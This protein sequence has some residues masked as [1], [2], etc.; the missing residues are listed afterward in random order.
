MNILKGNGF[1][2]ENGGNEIVEMPD[3]CPFCHFSIKPILL[4]CTHKQFNY[5]EVFMVCP[6]ENCQSSFIAYYDQIEK[7]LY[8]FTGFVSKGRPE[9]RNFSEVINKISSSF[10]KIYN[11]A[12]A[13]EQNNLHEICGMA[14]R[15][16]FEFLI[17]DYLIKI[18]PKERAFIK[19]QTR[20]IE[21]IRKYLQNPQLIDVVER[22][23]WLGNDETHYQRK[24]K[25]RDLKD[26][27]KLIELSI[28]WIESE[29][30]K[31]TMKRAL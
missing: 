4:K 22:T 12:F 15:K 1:K 3:K 19:K 27:K 26:L 11:E 14:Y 7:N 23:F 24:W 20:I 9:K 2:G 29:Y 21:L 5:L 25:N 13:A 6:N 10:C 16:S 18:N 28:N 17:R 8:S 31:R 30:Y